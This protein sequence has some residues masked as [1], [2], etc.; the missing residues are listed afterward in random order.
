M[1]LCPS[2]VV[3]PEA[4]SF[5]AARPL[6]QTQLR[7][8]SSS[9]SNVS[10]PASQE[11][12]FQH[13]EIAVPVRVHPAS[14]LRPQPVSYCLFFLFCF[15]FL[16][17]KR[18]FLLTEEYIIG[19]TAVDSKRDDVEQRTP[20]RCLQCGYPMHK[21]R[22][23]PVLPL[24]PDLF[25]KMTARRWGGKTKNK[26]NLVMADLDDLPRQKSGW[27]SAPAEASS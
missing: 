1:V 12:T 20:Q 15:C 11:N 9:S 24:P 14:L 7:C 16:Q 13:L 10:Q 2:S 18:R 25:G 6:F 19:F 3:G 26:G 8:R 22:E 5:R 21:V 23:A 17:R 27:P 4:C